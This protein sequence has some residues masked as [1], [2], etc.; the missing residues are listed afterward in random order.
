MNGILL[1]LLLKEI[2][3]K[4]IGTY[5]DEILIRDR[6]LQII[7]RQGSLYVSLYPEALALCHAPTDKQ[8]YAKLPAF[9]HE[10]SSGRIVA[11]DQSHFLPIVVM[12][13]ERSVRG[14]TTDCTLQVSFYRHAPNLSLVSEGRRRSLYRR[15]IAKQPKRSILEISDR[16]V[17]KLLALP[18]PEREGRITD[19]IEGIDRFLAHDLTLERVKILRD[20]LQGKKHTF[21]LIQM[22]PVHISLFSDI[23]VKRSTSLN[24]LFQHVIRNYQGMR[25]EMERTQNLK[26][27]RRNLT[28]KI[29]RLQSKLLVEK[30]IEALKRAGELILSNIASLKKGSTE[31]NMRDP[32]TNTLRAIKLDASMTP[33]ENAQNY[34]KQYKKAKRGQPILKKKIEELQS[35]LKNCEDTVIVPQGG[36]VGRV[37][38]RQKTQP[39]RVFPLTSGAIVYVGK[40]ARSN[41]ELTFSFARPNDY[42]FHVRGYEG[43]HVILRVNIPKGQ[44]PRREDLENAGAIAAYFS[45]ARTQRNV[46]VSYTQ[47][48]YLKKAKK[49]KVGTVT[50]MREE[51]LF[52]DPLKPG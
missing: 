42:F 26:L 31:L 21:T 5:I 37:R 10:L 51:V 13:I 33:Q 50:L 45:K 6:F 32:Y 43:A 2:R 1:H 35:H 20:I 41:D 17:E 27:L 4:V 22:A 7:R 29:K 14:K 48:K 28:R 23:G 30:E 18:A 47:R 36:S 44:R 25:D 40:N 15:T 16:S 39:F 12:T 8:G 52:V 49:G 11:L 24:R 38:D 46:A 3:S 34:F 19:S 9:T